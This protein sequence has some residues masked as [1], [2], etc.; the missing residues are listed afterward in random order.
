[1]L[2]DAHDPHAKFCP[3]RQ[4]ANPFIGGSYEFLG[5]AARL[6]DARTMFLHTATG[7][8]PAM[9]MSKVAEGSAYALAVKDANGEP[10]DGGKTCKVTLPGRVPVK[11]F[12][13][14][15]VHDNQTRSLL[16]TDRKLAGLDST[17]KKVAAEADGSV[18]IWFGPSVPEGHEAN[19]IQTMPGQGWNTILRLYG[20]LE[21]WI[22]KSWKPGDLEEVK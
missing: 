12:W 8:T 18:T 2:F 13:S 22:D 15:V 11:Q 16:E 1:V 20:P 3:D 9:S 10:R 19:W 14:F 5:G 17:D 7:I 4:W 6:L 21:P